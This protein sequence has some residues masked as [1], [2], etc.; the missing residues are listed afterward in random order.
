MPKLEIINE[1]DK[2]RR[3]YWVAELK[4]ISGH[5]GNDSSKLEDDLKNEISK[6]G[7]ESLI[8]HLRLCGAIPEEYK[9]DDLPPKNR[10]ESMLF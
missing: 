7:V 8:S 2:K 9:H 3:K 6:D 10:L 1:T 5:F 4:K